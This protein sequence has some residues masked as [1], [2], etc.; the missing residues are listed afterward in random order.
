MLRAL[1]L[2][3]AVAALPELSL[4]VPLPCAAGNCTAALGAALQTCARSASPCRVTLDAGTYA[5][6]GSA[7]PAAPGR[8]TVPRLS[9]L[10]ASAPFSLAGAGSGAT[11]LLLD[12]IATAVYVAG[13]AAS[14]S[15]SGFAIA[16]ARAPYTLGVVVAAS[17]AAS[18]LAVDGGA[19]ALD[20]GTLGRL[21][22]LLQAQAALSFDPV[23]RR[24]PPGA[25]DIYATANALPLGI[26][27]ANAG[28]FN[29]SLPAE[30][31]LGDTI[32]LRHVVYGATGI[33]AHHSGGLAVTDVALSGVAGMGVYASAVGDVTLDG[34]RLTRD[35]GAPMSINADGLHICNPRGGAVVVRNCV[36]E[37]QG[38]DGLNVNTLYLSIEALPDAH[39]LRLGKWGALFPAGLLPLQAGDTLAFVSRASMRE[40]G[41]AAVAAVS[42]RNGSVTLAGA[43]LPPGAALYDLVYSLN[44]TAASVEVR[45]NTF[46][47]NRARGALLKAHNL[48]AVNNIF[49]FTSGPAAQAIPDGCA[50]YEGITLRNWSF[51]NNTVYEGDY[52]GDSQAAQ[53]FVGASTP[54][55][56]GSVPSDKHCSAPLA[57]PV[58]A[59]LRVEGNTFHLR[60]GKAAFAVSAAAGVSVVGNT[61]L[62][63]AGQALAPFDF[64]G[65]ALQEAVA[66]GNSCPA[67]PG[68]VC[69]V[70]GF[71]ATPSL[72]PPAPAPAPP[73]FV[74]LPLPDPSA[75]CLD[76]SQYGIFFCKAATNASWEFAV[77]G[78]G[79]PTT[80]SPPQSAA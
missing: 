27:A 3:S 9:L 77:Q 12:D 43:G 76:G 57:A 78:G 52:G 55:Y 22:W 41:T 50:W 48:L 65:Q 14:A 37:G 71:N 15:F 67:R 45:N 35:G 4:H 32:I 1:L 2:L 74:Y 49:N 10:G 8:P 20:A 61:V 30:L 40:V 31:R 64:V 68:G 75:Q 17:P 38:D 51:V 26:V 16:S 53:L 73:A 42:Q 18:V 36:L 59:G 13:A 24:V 25:T 7:F 29:V 39:T 62:A 28:Y 54:A 46:T 6:T 21:P 11:T 70:S 69:A 56:N 60:S 63:A 19:Y 23:N 33:E 72:A 66:G 34:V 79:G 5:L 58:H 80:C 47:Q 44:G